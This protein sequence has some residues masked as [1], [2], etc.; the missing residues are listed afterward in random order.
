[1]DTSVIILLSVG[2]VL[3]VYQLFF[4]KDDD[5]LDSYGKAKRKTSKS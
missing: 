2:A 5:E 3:L 1:M 4:R